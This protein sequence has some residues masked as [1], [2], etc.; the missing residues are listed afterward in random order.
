MEHRINVHV[1]ARCAE[2]SLQCDVNILELCIF[3]NDFLDFT[4]SVSMSSASLFGVTS[5]R[6]FSTTGCL[7]HIHK[8]TR[9]RVVDNSKLGKEAMMEGKPPKVIHVYNK[10][11]R[12]D[13]GDKVLLTI[14]GQM[15]KGIVVGAKWKEQQVLR[16]RFD[17]NNVVLIDDS[18][19][20]LG[21]RILAPLPM[22]LRSQKEEYN[23]LISIATRFV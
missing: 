9:L 13:L 21:S 8:L 4:S 10:T 22:K 7:E 17:S 6:V 1:F 20:P 2:I 15:K 12:A 11:G 18:G 3:I 16:P 23:K 19:N 14:K 5:C